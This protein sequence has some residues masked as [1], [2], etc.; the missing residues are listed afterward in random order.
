M[1]SHSRDLEQFVSVS[2]DRP[3]RAKA[4]LDFER[5]EDDELGFKKNDIIT[6]RWKRGGEGEGVVSCFI[7]LKNIF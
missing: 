5:H 4:L 2:A 7:V 1:E 3:K 6:V